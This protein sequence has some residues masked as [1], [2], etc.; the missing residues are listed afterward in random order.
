MKTVH[1]RMFSHPNNKEYSYYV[2]HECGG[3]SERLDTVTFDP[4]ISF[5][6]LRE[7][8]EEREVNGIMKRT[9]FYT[10]FIH[11]MQRCPNPLGYQDKESLS[12]YRIG[13]LNIVD[14]KYITPTAKDITLLQED[15]E[16]E[17][18]SK[19]VSNFLSTDFVLIPTAQ[20]HPRTGT[21]SDTL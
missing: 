19:I 3:L 4:S 1:L 5:T 17:P 14:E 21:L 18:I 2:S 20:I 13:L 6:Q 12:S 8:I 9:T 15:A 10:E 7:K 16:S 11:F